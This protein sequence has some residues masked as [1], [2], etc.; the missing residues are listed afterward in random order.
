MIRS[1]RRVEAPKLRAYL[2]NVALVHTQCR[3]HA[4]KNARVVNED[5]M[6]ERGFVRAGGVSR[7]V[8]TIL[9]A[10]VARVSAYGEHH[11]LEPGDAL[12]VDAKQEV[13]MRQA[14]DAYEAIAFEWS[15]GFL[16]SPRAQIDRA[17]L[18]ADELEEARAV[19]TAA[20]DETSAPARV[21][22]RLCTMLGKK[23]RASLDERVPERAQDL[24][25]VL[26]EALSALAKQP[27]L[28]E[29]SERLGVST[30]Q[31]NRI[32]RVYNETYGF[33]ATGWI[34]TRN[35]RRLLIGATLMTAPKATAS[36]VARVVGYQSA[37]AFARAL[38]LAGLPAPTDIAAEVARIGD[39][40]MFPSDA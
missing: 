32:V 15:P 36:Y 5:I 19:W 21:V 31:L 23:P 17:G 12:V 6:L 26:D 20:R 30:R 24:T 29:L 28:D 10:G 3:L 22:E 2:S 34:D 35:R 39:E 25:H 37:T 18:S 14:G 38:G 7:P 13:H 16:G 4:V 11:W 27:M 40:T 8:M 1:T 9:L 33:N